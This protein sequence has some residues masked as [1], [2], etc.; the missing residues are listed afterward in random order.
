MVNG[1]KKTV[2]YVT[3]KKSREIV[4]LIKNAWRNIFHES[5]ATMD[6]KLLK[7]FRLS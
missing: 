3:A 2:E 1:E 4:I 7:V 5:N 6:G